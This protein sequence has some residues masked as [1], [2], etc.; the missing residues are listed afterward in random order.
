MS[1]SGK[2]F[3]TSLP[4]DLVMSISPAVANMF[5]MSVWFIPFPN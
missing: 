4:A 5:K 2:V 1:Q 3:I